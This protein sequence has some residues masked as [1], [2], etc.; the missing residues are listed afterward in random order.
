MKIPTRFL[1]I[2]VFFVISPFVFAVWHF[3]IQSPQKHVQQAEVTATAQTLR[4]A[5]ISWEKR[6]KEIGPEKASKEFVSQAPSL[7]LSTHDQAHA[8]G[9]ALYAVEGLNGLGYCDSSFEFGCYH[10]FFGVAVAEEGIGVLSKFDEACK[11]AYPK[12]YMPCQ[13]GI[14]HGIL[15]YTD[16]ENLIDALKLCETVSTLPTGGC[17]SGVF[18]ENNFHTMD[19]SVGTSFLRSTDNDLYAP[20]NTLPERFQ[21]SCYFEQVQ[22]WQN[23]FNNDFEYLGKLCVALPANSAEYTACY[24]GIG[25]YVAAFAAREYQGIINQCATMPDDQ[26][27]ASC[28]EGA[29]WLLL[30]EEKTRDSAHSLC[31]S[32]KEPYQSACLQKL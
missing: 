1:A 14:G 17:S 30:S 18:M 26:S 27:V 10:S 31:T 20:C 9:E 23:L 7:P 16:Y 11:S 3:F 25:N 22:W 29:S 19:T 24:N 4:E 2:L 6:I 32:L 21:A 15:V 12:M 5:K 13:H 8:F 28:H